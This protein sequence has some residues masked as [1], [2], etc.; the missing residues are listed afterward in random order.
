MATGMHSF[1]PEPRQCAG[2]RLW[3]RHGSAGLPL[4]WIP[5]FAGMAT[6]RTP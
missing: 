6:C 1:R 3:R 2:P 5:V 4:A